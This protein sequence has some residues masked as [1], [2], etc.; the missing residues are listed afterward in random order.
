VDGLIF[1][2]DRAAYEQALGERTGS[3][4]TPIVLMK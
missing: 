3:E 1:V 4:P 2:F